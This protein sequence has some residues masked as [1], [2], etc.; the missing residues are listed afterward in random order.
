MNILRTSLLLLTFAATTAFADDLNVTVDQNRR[1][2][3]AA[4]RRGTFD[5]AITDAVSDSV[6]ASIQQAMTQ[7][8]ASSSAASGSY[9][10]VDKQK[11]DALLKDYAEMRDLAKDL[12]VIGMKQMDEIKRLKAE[13]AKK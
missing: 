3:T 9:V 6:A 11:L 8:N 12:A 7:T 10:A 2:L 4:E 13:L 1:P 5:R